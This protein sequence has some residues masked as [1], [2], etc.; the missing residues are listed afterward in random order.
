MK[1]KKIFFFLFIVCC[2]FSFLDLLITR[3]GEK[4]YYE[5]HEKKTVVQ[6]SLVKGILVYGNDHIYFFKW[7]ITY[8]KEINH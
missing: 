2:M 3:F 4:K 6:D 8:L 5:I 1:T 7:N